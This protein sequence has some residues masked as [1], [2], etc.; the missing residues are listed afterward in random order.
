MVTA[1]KV[2]GGFWGQLPERERQL[3]QSA[4]RARIFPPDAT[5][6]AQGDLATHV[7]V[8]VSGWV[9]VTVVTGGGQ[10]SLLAL[11]GNGDVVGELAGE[12]AGCRTATVKT[13]GQVRSIIVPHPRFV[14][15][16]DTN[17]A[18]AGAYR[19]ALTERWNDTAESLRIQSISSGAERLARLLLELAAEHGRGD[20]HHTTIELPLSQEELASLASASRATVTRA[21]GAWRRRRLVETSPRHITITDRDALARIAVLGPD[22]PG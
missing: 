7:F 11:R 9:K 21:L 20:E 3:L 17:P 10:Q 8:L 12:V 22:W 5:V 1:G 13:I 19:H 14:T 15:F 2:A 6:C 18:A 16:L 4:G